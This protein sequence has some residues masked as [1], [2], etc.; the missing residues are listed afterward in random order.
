MAAEGD[1]NIV[2][3]TYTGADG[4]V[5]PREATHIFVKARVVRREAFRF[6]PNIVEVIC[7][8]NVE[9]IE[10]AAFQGCRRLRRVI[11]RGVKVIEEDTFF[12]CRA[13]EDVECNKLE[14]VGCGAFYLCESLR[15]I[16][17]PSARIVVSSAF[18]GCEA[19][20]DVKFGRKLER[21]EENAFED[22]VNLER[23]T[24]PLKDGL[25]TSDDIFTACNNLHQVYLIEGELH[26]TMAALH[27]REW[28][29]DMNEEIDSI[30]QILPNAP[31]GGWDDEF[32]E[33]D[34]GEK[35]QT[36]RDWIR[37]VVDKLIRYRAEHQRL[38]NEAATTLQIVLPNNDIVM[39]NVLPFLELPSY[40]FEVGDDDEEDTDGSDD[41]E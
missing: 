33:G 15:S 6:H 32:E 4:E 5:I 35:A 22:C 30:N 28:R 29:S 38:L 19:L 13:L 3:F 25:V 37:S 16:N 31:A 39:N 34:P 26:E 21:M 12:K 11:M 40:T 36:I 41:E 14:R 18:E 10:E 7:D 2:Q 20:K 27:L 1:N 23:I 17:L 9:E 8:E 24:I